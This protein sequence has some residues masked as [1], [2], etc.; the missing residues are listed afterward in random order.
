MADAVIG[1][2]PL[3]TKTPPPGTKIIRR[4]YNAQRF[5][6]HLLSTRL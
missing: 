4:Q 5:Y 2:T 3:S 1:D 6:W